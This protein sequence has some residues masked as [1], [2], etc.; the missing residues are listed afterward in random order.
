MQHR[1][2]KASS[3][4]AVTYLMLLLL[5]GC[6]KDSPKTAQPNDPIENTVE[7]NEA[8]KQEGNITSSQ[9]IPKAKDLIFTDQIS[10]ESEVLPV[11]ENHCVL[12][13]AEGTA[14]AFHMKLDVASDATAYAFA[15]GRLVE[16]G[17]MPPWP[18]SEKS[19]LFMGDHSITSDQK[20]AVLK[21]ANQGGPIDVDPN[22]K[23]FSQRPVMTINNP[24]LVVTSASGPYQGSRD[25]LDDYRCV[26]LTPM[27]T[28]QS[29]FL[30]PTSYRTK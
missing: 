29:G 20:E 19:P 17:D 4:A 15:I 23:M 30:L 6:S 16:S 28:K 2:F 26:I 22:R 25:T 13:H 18:A 12:C 9:E 8:P 11:L 10:F 5:S 27:W 7:I 3:I 1:T 14:G 21:W 24:D